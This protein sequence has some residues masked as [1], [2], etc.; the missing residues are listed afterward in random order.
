VWKSFCQDVIAFAPLSDAEYFWTFSIFK[1]PHARFFPSFYVDP[2]LMQV[3]KTPPFVVDFFFAAVS[4]LVVRLFGM[5][6]DACRTFFFFF[7]KTARPLTL[8]MLS[9]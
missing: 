3:I 6:P 8:Q 7:S 2:V 5:M 1:L 9:P 4:F